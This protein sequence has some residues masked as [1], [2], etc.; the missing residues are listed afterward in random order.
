[1]VCC[2]QLHICTVPCLRCLLQAAGQ[3]GI[4]LLDA[5]LLVLLVQQRGLRQRYQHRLLR[6]P[7]AQLALQSSAGGPVRLEPSQGS[8]IL[9]LSA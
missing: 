6:Q 9:S 1:L 5:V 8:P 4:E 2:E 7:N 3:G